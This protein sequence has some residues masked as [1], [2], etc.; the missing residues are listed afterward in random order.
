MTLLRDVKSVQV[1]SKVEIVPMTPTSVTRVRVTL[2]ANVSTH[3]AHSD[4]T[5]MKGTRKPTPPRAR[6]CNCYF[7]MTTRTIVMMMMTMISI[8]VIIDFTVIVM[9]KV[10][11]MTVTTMK[12]IM[13]VDIVEMVAM[14]VITVVMIIYFY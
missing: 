14:K 5:A 9:M 7:A 3:R 11:V 4:V 2:I 12:V 6:V 1:D 10:T 8:I 13:M